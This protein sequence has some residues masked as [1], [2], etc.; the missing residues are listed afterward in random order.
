[1]YPKHWK[2]L[3]ELSADDVYT[4]VNQLTLH[5]SRGPLI[6]LRYK[7]GLA[8]STKPVLGHKDSFILMDKPSH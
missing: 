8:T 3:E 5:L 7:L 4:K 1:M 6:K 2:A